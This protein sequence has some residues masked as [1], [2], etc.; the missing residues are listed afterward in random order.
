M[1]FK[2]I[3]TDFQHGFVVTVSDEFPE[4]CQIWEFREPNHLAEKCWE[5]GLH[6]HKIFAGSFRSLYPYWAA[7]DS[8]AMIQNGELFKMLESPTLPSTMSEKDFWALHDKMN[9]RSYS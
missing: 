6:W 9:N 2:E 1:A 3:V 5:N 4:E 7:Y 8:Y